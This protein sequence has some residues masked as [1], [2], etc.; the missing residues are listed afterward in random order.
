[1]QDFG[2]VWEDVFV[3]LVGLKAVVL[4]RLLPGGQW[5]E[6]RGPTIPLSRS[7]FMFFFAFGPL[8]REEMTLSRLTAPI[9]LFLPI[10]S[11][12]NTSV[13][14]SRET[15]LLLTQTKTKNRCTITVYCQKLKN[16]HQKKKKQQV[17][18]G[19]LLLLI[20]LDGSSAEDR[21][22]PRKV[23]FNLTKSNTFEF[24]IYWQIKQ[25]WMEKEPHTV[26]TH[27]AVWLASGSLPFL[28]GVCMITWVL[29][30]PSQLSKISIKVDWRV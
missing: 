13:V 25:K 6:S 3:T 19:C 10:I 1:M 30:F 9:P 14:F 27:W 24:S 8:D 26:V 17:P 18:L 4:E 2:Q 16:K 21:S 28:C 20:Y 5:T 12:F 22:P 15:L 23:W 7:F 11:P 29:Q